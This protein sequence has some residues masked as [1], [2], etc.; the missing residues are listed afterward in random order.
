MIIKLLHISS[1]STRNVQNIQAVQDSAAHC[2]HRVLPWMNLR[3][4][5]KDLLHTHTHPL[6]IFSSIVILAAHPTTPAP[7]H[8][9]LLH[10]LTQPGCVIMLQALLRGSA[11]LE[12]AIVVKGLMAA[13]LLACT[14]FA[15]H[16]GNSGSS[17]STEQLCGIFDLL[18]SCHKVILVRQDI[19][20]T[21]SL[22]AL[23]L[24]RVFVRLST[25]LS[26]R[27]HDIEGMKVHRIQ[28]VAAF[29]IHLLT[30]K[31]RPV[32]SRPT[33]QNYN[34]TANKV[35]DTC[36]GERLLIKCCYL[37]CENLSGL[38]DSVIKTHSCKG[39]EKVGYCSVKCQKGHWADGGHSNVCDGSSL[40]K[41]M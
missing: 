6:D 28:C 8:H 4:L 35:S 29:S 19:N 38:I 33:R 5:D 13:G 11:Q 26:D 18:V 3:R 12:P 20:Y 22:C 27:Q 34:I 1:P 21:T 31:I 10:T 7:S 41:Y 30:W 37:G 14:I 25:G 16:D 2:I 24:I 40:S 17:I 39:C 32:N 15:R 9:N 36:G 23:Q